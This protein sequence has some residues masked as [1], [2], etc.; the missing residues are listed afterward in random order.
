MRLPFDRLH[1]FL[2]QHN[3]IAV[4]GHEE[5]DADCLCSQLAVASLLRRSGSEPRLMSPGPFL[6]PEVQEYAKYFETD[7]EGFDTPEAALVLDCSTLDRIGPLS[8]I[9]EALPTAVVDHHAS[10]T[11]FGDVRVIDPGAP[12]VTFLIHA[13]MSYLGTA[14][15]Q[16]ET[17]WLL[18]GLCTDT[19]Y[20]RHLGEGSGAAFRAAADLVD[21]GASPK[22]MY[23]KMYGNQSFESRRQVGRLLARTERYF[24]GQVLFTYEGIAEQVEFEGAHADSDTVYQ[25]LQQVVGCRA[26]VFIRSEEANRQ[27]VGLR[28]LTTPDVGSIARRLGG[29]GHANA[30][31]YTTEG[32]LEEARDHILEELGLELGPGHQK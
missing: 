19:G 13:Y 10:G 7:V 31:G 17:L 14:P 21:A 12:S 27:S 29:G 11:V 26:V 3:S 15:T 6:R 5:P 30:S 28:S 9:I 32:S 23:R 8:K 18:F 20:F 25:Q 16:E 4:I 1:E 24:D 2:S 22:S